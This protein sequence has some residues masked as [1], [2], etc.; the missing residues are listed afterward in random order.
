M[1][2]TKFE[3]ENL[4]ALSKPTFEPDPVPPFGFAT[5]VGAYVNQE[6]RLREVEMLGWRA[7]MFA[8]LAF[9][10]LLLLRL[11]TESYWEDAEPGTTKLLSIDS[12]NDL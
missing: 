1:E 5:R 12:T 3:W 2:P 7:L 4:V 10:F 6:R 11:N 9:V 8:S